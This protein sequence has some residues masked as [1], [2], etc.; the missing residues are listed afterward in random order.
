MTSQEMT[1]WQAWERANGPL[2]RK[3]DDILAGR[4]AYQVAVAFADKKSAKKVKI[5]DFIPQWGARKGPKER[6]T[7]EQMKA[8]L[9]DIT[10]KFQ[11]SAKQ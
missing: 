9:L 4:L 3:R 10:A 6:Q 7:P 11:A 8:V 5:E 2:G 1:R